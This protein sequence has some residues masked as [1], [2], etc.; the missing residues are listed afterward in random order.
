[1][2]CRKTAIVRMEEAYMRL[3]IEYDNPTYKTEICKN[4]ANLEQE[5]KIY[6]EVIH[7][8]GD[9]NKWFSSIEFS[10]DDYICSRTCGN[11]IERLLSN[12]NIQQCEND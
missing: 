6:P 1:M 4:I 9:T 10:E 2:L 5:L 3:I 7:R 12:L 11:F 8:K